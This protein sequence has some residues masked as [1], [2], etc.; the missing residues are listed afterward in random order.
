M[1]KR[2]MAF[3]ALCFLIMIQGCK[4][5]MEL[6]PQDYFSGQQL[7]LARAIEEGNVDV[8]KTL[9]PDSNLNQPG[10]QDMTLLFWA[11]GNAINDKKTSPHLKVITL[12]V[13]A[14]AD[15]LQPRPQGKSSPAEFALKGDSADWINAMLDGGLSPDVKDKVFHEP[16]IF[17]AIKAQNTET[18]EA[19]L[20]RGAD[21]NAANSLG[22]TLVFDA[23]DNQS[24]DHVLL[25]LDRGADPS[26]KAKNGWS[27]SNALA[28]ALSGLE[29]G[30]EHYEKLNEI[31]EKLIQKGGKWPPEPVR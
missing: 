15:P 7:E 11:L 16:I 8:V 17:Q 21:V 25:L 28:D 29:K 20:D 5:D 13:E 18:L 1:K 23:L 31:K 26:I 27:M 14:G 30:S 19:M 22:K 2:L 10:K 9:A 3:V 24:Y 4:Q 6:N 12:L